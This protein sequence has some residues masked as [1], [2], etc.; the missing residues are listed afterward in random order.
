MKKIVLFLIFSLFISN[1]NLFSQVKT[2]ENGDVLVFQMKNKMNVHFGSEETPV[3]GIQLVLGGPFVWRKGNPIGAIIQEKDVVKMT[4]KRR[5]NKQNPFVYYNSIFGV[6]TKGE[7]V[8]VRFEEAYAY[9]PE[10]QW[11]FQNGPAL[12]IEGV[13][14][15]LGVTQIQ[16][17]SSNDFF[18]G[19][20]FLQNGDIVVMVTLRKMT[21]N[22]F[23]FSFKNYGCI[24]A[25]LINSG[26]GVY[27]NISNNLYRS[28]GSYRKKFGKN[29]NK[30]NFLFY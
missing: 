29:T 12:L 26:E 15:S 28:H 19:I 25:L 7:P 18:S 30:L 13:V 2:I 1:L 23:S 24:N 14:P 17:I 16:N 11:A 27:Y 5:L 8:M 20:G 10:M 22:Q 3:N 6:N 4:S 9:L 21:I